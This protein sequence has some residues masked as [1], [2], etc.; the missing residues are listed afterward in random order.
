MEQHKLIEKI[1]ELHES[2]DAGR[3]LG[4]YMA[5]V[6]GSLRSLYELCLRHDQFKYPERISIRGY[7]Y[8]T[9]VVKVNRFVEESDLQK[10]DHAFCSGLFI[11]VEG[12]FIDRYMMAKLFNAKL[13]DSDFIYESDI[14]KYRL[15]HDLRYNT[16]RRL[17]NGQGF[18]IRE[19]DFNEKYIPYQ[20]NWEFLEL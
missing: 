19:N 17:T 9:R 14:D 13:Q 5:W 20:G 12:A 18:V 16:V 15:P 1:R 6:D 8:V 11:A 4:D 2:E 7:R 3:L 10:V